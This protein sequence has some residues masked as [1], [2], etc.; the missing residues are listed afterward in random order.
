[1]G[2][3]QR[4]AL[5]VIIGLTA[6]ATLLV[7]YLADEPNRRAA[8][9]QEQTEAALER[10]MSTYTQFCVACHGP[11]GQGLLETGRIGW[12]L[13]GDYVGPR[14]PNFRE[15]VDERS[16]TERNQTEDPVEWARREATIAAAIYEGRG[17]MPAW[18]EDVG[19]ELNDEQIRELVLLIH[20]GD[21]NEVYNHVIEVNEGYP[22]VPPAGGANPGRTSVEVQEA[23]AEDIIQINAVGLEW[24]PDV[25][26]VPVGGTI[27]LVN[28]GSGGFHTFVI[29]GYNDDAPVDMPVGETIEWQV[30]DDLPPGEYTFYCS[31]PGHAEAGMVGSITI[32]PALD[33]EPEDEGEAVE[34]QPEATTP[35]EG[36]LENVTPELPS[37][38]ESG[39]QREEVGSAAEASTDAPTL[40]AFDIGW[41]PTEL[42][43]AAGG[44]I[45]MVNIG[46]AE[47][48]FAI[49]GYQNGEVL[50]DI[51]VGGEPV[52]WQVPDDLAPGTYTFFCAVPGHREA[53]MEGTLTITG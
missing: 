35:G 9:A 42:T 44:A 34:V 15:G 3:V 49:D 1:V 47:H 6:L 48:N 53:G 2:A 27:Q 19:G 33:T 28:D 50:Q 24:Q 38:D 36:D 22:T 14:D 29:E 20:E 8:E 30:P 39:E 23:E 41:E 45:T 7:I 32:L 12:P 43:V 52:T 18:G 40:E 26:Q 21:W 5:V 46:N 37:D 11:G 10:A 13:A 4:L 25:V 17:A 16:V 31:V 51:P